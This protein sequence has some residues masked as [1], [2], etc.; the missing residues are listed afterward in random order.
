M[1]EINPL[2]P[3]GRA[4]NDFGG[5]PVQLAVEG[6]ASFATRDMAAAIRRILV[7]E[8]PGREHLSERQIRVFL[9]ERNRTWLSAAELEQLGLPLALANEAVAWFEYDW[10]EYFTMKDARAWA[11]QN[12]GKP[13]QQVLQDPEPRVGVKVGG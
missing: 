13:L 3:L 1:S 5:S 8:A 9:R 10:K 7:E 6:L 2:S 12:K 11:M 4:V